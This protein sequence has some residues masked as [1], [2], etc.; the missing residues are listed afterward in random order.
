MLRPLLAAMLLV[1]CAATAG[2]EIN[3]T[4]TLSS[5]TTLAQGTTRSTT[6]TT[7]Q[8][9]VTNGTTTGTTSPGV[10]TPGVTT[11][12]TTTGVTTTTGT[13]GGTTTGAVT[14]TAVPGVPR[15][16]AIIVCGEDISTGAN[17]LV[18]FSSSTSTGGPTLAPAAPCAQALA[19]LFVAGY[20]IIDVQSV[21]QQVQYTL[22]R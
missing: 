16:A 17:R 6:G 12:G 13:T 10:T 20:G 7:T 19:D 2:A 3:T 15:D 18:V 21:N 14:G 8:G 1:S 5:N 4:G 22:A 11:P 9:T